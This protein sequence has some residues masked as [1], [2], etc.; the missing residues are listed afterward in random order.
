[1]VV[2][3]VPMLIS[4]VPATA[5]VRLTVPLTPYWLVAGRQ[6]EGVAVSVNPPVH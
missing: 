3:E 1:M 6:A 2:V 4:S 5:L